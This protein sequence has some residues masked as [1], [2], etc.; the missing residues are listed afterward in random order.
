V[1]VNIK[2]YINLPSGTRAAVELSTHDPKFDGS[3]PAAVGSG[4]KC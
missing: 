1:G 4:R 3:N 2:K